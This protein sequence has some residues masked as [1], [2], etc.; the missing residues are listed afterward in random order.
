MGK[1]NRDRIKSILENV[2]DGTSTIDEAMNLLRSFPYENIDFARID[3]H[4]G[5]RTGI[6]EVIYTPGKTP[7][8]VADIARSMS[9]C[10]VTVL[11]T[12]ASR[13]I[14]LEIRPEFQ[15]IEYHEQ[16]SIISIGDFPEPCGAGDILVISA[17]TTDI[18]VAEEAAVT[19]RATGNSVITIY[20]AGVAGIHRLLDRLDVIQSASVI[21]AVAGM[22]GALPS[23]I[24]GLAGRPVIAVPTS[25][26]YGAGFGG[27]APLLTMLNS[28][29]PGIAVVNI[30]NGFGAGCMA[31]M[32]NRKQT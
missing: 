32:I 19:A 7:R 18:P 11:A 26:G 21:I 17:G 9:S 3:T 31:A 6:P 4:R 15:K 12:R 5:L 22:E 28:C 30:D 23:V 25:V 27:V 8:Q 13:D 10:G 16:A 14:Y 20:D 24:A 1:L 29:A 2:K